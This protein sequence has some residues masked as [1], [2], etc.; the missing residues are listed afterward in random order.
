MIAD[1]N[2]PHFRIPVAR[3]AKCNA[4]F[5]FD[6]FQSIKS[7]IA[8]TLSK[9]AIQKLRIKRFLMPNKRKL[10]KE[11]KFLTVRIPLKKAFKGHEDVMDYAGIM[12]DDISIA[13]AQILTRVLVAFTTTPRLVGMFKH[14]E[15]HI[16]SC[17]HFRSDVKLTSPIEVF[18]MRERAMVDM[19]T[20]LFDSLYEN[21]FV[22]IDRSLYG[23]KTKN[24]M[25]E[26]IVLALPDGYSIVE[27]DQLPSKHTV[28][29]LQQFDSASDI[30]VSSS[31]YK[32][33][34]KTL[35]KLSVISANLILKKTKGDRD[36]REKSEAGDDVS[37]GGNGRGATVITSSCGM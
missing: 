8:E 36:E 22:L 28:R 1:L 6:E 31:T 33:D 17:S 32:D 13:P 10:S 30:T 3:V 12:I 24:P 29:A 34:E 26:I 19:R 14:I 21:D 27:E 18:S 2:E 37:R 5:T 4:H 35:E 15:E 9:L 25:L 23:T 20:I 16:G 11:P 7:D